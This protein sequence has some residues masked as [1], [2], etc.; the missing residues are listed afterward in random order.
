M[1]SKTDTVNKKEVS[2]DS[3]E[4]NWQDW[5]LSLHSIWKF[6]TPFGRGEKNKK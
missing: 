2:I 1:S 5:K 4:K 6:N 3:A